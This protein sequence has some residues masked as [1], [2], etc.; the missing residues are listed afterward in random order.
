MYTWVAALGG[1]I[2]T[3]ARP[4]GTEKAGIPLFVARAPYQGLQPGKI[5]AGSDGALFAYNGQEILEGR[6]EVLMNQGQWAPDVAGR[7]PIGAGSSAPY[8]YAIA[9]GHDSDATPLFVARARHAGGLHPGKYRHGFAGAHIGFDGKE[10]AGI[11]PFEVLVDS[12][13]EWIPATGGA[14]PAGC[15]PNGEEASGEPLYLVRAGLGRGIHPGKI[16][17]PWEAAD[18]PYDGLEDAV[19]ALHKEFALDRE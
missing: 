10:I 2:P 4:N 8:G 17:P 13:Y 11:T 15:A 9:F 1:T 18:V 7:L 5:R 14:I 3:G 12:A 19:R 16:R 6:Y